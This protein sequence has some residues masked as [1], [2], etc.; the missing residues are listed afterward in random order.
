MLHCYLLLFFIL[1]IFLTNVSLSHVASGSE[2]D[3]DTDSTQL[4]ERSE[5]DSIAESIASSDNGQVAD[6]G[7]GRE[8]GRG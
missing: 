8:R 5:R 7:R 1:I 2:R 3:T 4:S 6:K